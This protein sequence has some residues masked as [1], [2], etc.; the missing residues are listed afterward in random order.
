MYQ[1]KYLGL[2]LVIERSKR[3]V[4]DF[5]RQK[6]VNKLKGWKEKLPSQA[7]KEVL[8]KSVVLALPTY[9]MSCYRLPK[10]L[11][12]NICS[13]MARFWWG[14]REDERKIHWIK[15]SRMTDIKSEG[16]L[17]FRDL[18]DFNMALLGK[19]LWRI[20]TRPDLLMSRIIKAKYF[21]GKP[22]WEA[23]QRGTDSWCWKSLLSAKGLLEEGMRIRV[24]DGANN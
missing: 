24:G 18:Q 23:Q 19:Q 12:R 6:T 9:V 11:C 15:W 3:Q 20:H 10:E 8:L 2:P 7:G 21:P 16:G 22:I 17:G 1:S 5:I 14:Q 13:E 4:F